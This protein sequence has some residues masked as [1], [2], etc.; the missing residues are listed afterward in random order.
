MCSTCLL[1]P[2]VVLL[3][4][5]T[6]LV[7][8]PLLSVLAVDRKREAE[9]TR[10]RREKVMSSAEEEARKMPR[11]DDTVTSMED[12][13]VNQTSAV[14]LPDVRALTQILECSLCLSLICEPISI[15]CGHSFCRVC[16]VKSLRRHRKRC[17]S[18]REVCHVSAE[19]ASENVMLKAMAIALDGDGYQARLEEVRLE[20]ASWTTQYPI[21]YYNSP[22]FPGNILSLHLFEPRY[23]LMMQRVVST[24]NAF[25]YVPN[26]T[27]YNA[28]VGDIALVAKMKEVE[29]MPGKGYK[30]DVNFCWIDFLMGLVV[31]RWQVFVG[32]FDNYQ[33]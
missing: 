1:V 14:V 27:N 12:S 19:N 16:L 4:V 11:L 2:F 9:V 26:F 6:I 32:S 33:K 15:S 3:V 17:P 13:N 5:G 7:K 29:F 22:I 21:F 25:A 31:F 18:C 8:Y 28:S 10:R 30:H 20:K 24:T 23:K